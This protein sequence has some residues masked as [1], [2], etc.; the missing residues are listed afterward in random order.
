MDHM[1]GCNPVTNGPL[2][3]VACKDPPKPVTLAPGTQRVL[4][5]S[6][7]TGLYLS[8]WNSSLPVQVNVSKEFLGYSEVFVIVDQGNGQ[9]SILSEGTEQYMSASSGGNDNTVANRGSPSGWEMFQLVDA[10]NGT[11]A[12][13]CFSNNKYLSVQPDGKLKNNVATYTD[14]AQQWNVINADSVPTSAPPP[15]NIDSGDQDGNGGYIGNE[16]G[17]GKVEATLAVLLGATLLAL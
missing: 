5:Q 11:F 14:P 7:L 17:V 8:G 15:Q 6:V 16:S 9:H 3:A 2:A 13:Q 10:G 1:P 4:L 12:I